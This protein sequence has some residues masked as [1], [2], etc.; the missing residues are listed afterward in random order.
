MVHEDGSCGF[1]VG[2]QV[3]SGID[4][5]RFENLWKLVGSEISRLSSSASLSLR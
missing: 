3:K 1:E 4:I 5:L 2:L